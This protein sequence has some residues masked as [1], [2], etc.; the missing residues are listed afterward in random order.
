MVTCYVGE[1]A[2]VYLL[3]VLAKGRRENFNAAEIA[4]FRQIAAV[5][6]G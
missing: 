6:S 2:P 4:V 1:E 3:A 5:L